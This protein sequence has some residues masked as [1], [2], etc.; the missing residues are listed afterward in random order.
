MRIALFHNLPSG[1]AKR[2]LYE[3]AKRLAANHHIDVYTL[4]CADHDFANLRPLVAS[5]KAFDF[6]PL[7]LLSSPLGRLNQAIRLADLLRL[8][9]LSRVIAHEIKSAHYDVVLAHPCQFTKSPSILRHLSS[10][11]AIYYC[12]E[13]LRLLYEAMP[14]RPYDHDD[15]SWRLMLNHVDPLPFL[16]HAAL[17]RIDQCNTRSASLVLVNSE[18]TRQAVHRIYQVEARVSYHGV[19][20]HRFR[21]LPVEKRHIVLSV[22]SLSPLKGFDFLIQAVARISSDQRPSLVI[23][24]NFQWPPE[25]IYLKQLAHDL[26]VE[27][28]LFASVSDEHLV[29]LYNQAKV[30]VY[31][32][33]REPFGLVPLESMACGTPIVGVREGGLQETIIH[34]RTGL[35]VERDCEQF[36]RAVQ[37]LLSNSTLASEYGRNGRE[38]VLRNW[39]WDQAVTTLESHLTACAR[40]K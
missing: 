8:S 4:T 31:A 38:H 20:A 36:A 27:L 10:P 5:H 32:P 29:Q 26:D 40:M 6:R 17:K 14:A 9:V 28:V 15:A 12:Q 25:R 22:G 35:L 34:E 19:D 24:S 2:T 3:S 11:P 33:L 7:P 18:F 39:T 37:H 21:P 1:G 30:T 13:P 16:Y 23:A